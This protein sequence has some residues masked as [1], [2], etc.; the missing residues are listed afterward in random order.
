MDINLIYIL[1]VLLFAIAGFITYEV[2]LAIV[3]RSAEGRKNSIFDNIHDH[4]NL[5]SYGACYDNCM[6]ESHWDPGH[7]PLCTATCN[8]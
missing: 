4:S 5:R 6:I 2:L 7:V 8:I 1:A 3:W